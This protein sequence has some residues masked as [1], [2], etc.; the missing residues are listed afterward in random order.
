MS[1]ENEWTARAKCRDSK[2]TLFVEGAAQR[3]AR[4]VCQGCPVRIDCLTEAL[5]NRIEWGIWGGLTE[6][7][8]RH[9]LRTRTEVTSWR[10]VLQPS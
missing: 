7:E 2:D 10:Q 5:D 1:I 4:V 3:K 8:R 6:R 9:L